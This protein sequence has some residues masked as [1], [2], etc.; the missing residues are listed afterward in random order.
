MDEKWATKGLLFSLF[1][2][3]SRLQSHFER[4]TGEVWSVLV[5]RPAH[6][7]DLRSRLRHVSSAASVAYSTGCHAVVCPA[8][9]ER[10]VAGL[11]H[12]YDATSIWDSS[13]RSPSVC[14]FGWPQRFDEAVVYRSSVLPYGLV[15]RIRRSHRR[16]PGSIPGVGKRL[17]ILFTL[18]HPLPGSN[19]VFLYFW[20]K[21]RFELVTGSFLCACF[22]FLP[23]A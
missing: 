4:W 2:L 8:L 11:I 6:S 10:V 13:H 22:F 7:A 12:A 23:I 21:E 17:F 18:H 19:S 1:L 14:S 3:K 15:V 5:V 20:K 16:G 9:W